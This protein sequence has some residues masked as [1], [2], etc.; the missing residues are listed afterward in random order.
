MQETG[1]YRA[2]D[3]VN[4]HARLMIS[5]VIVA[6]L[7]LGLAGSIVAN[8]D[9]P[10]F[11]PAGEIFETADRADNVLRSESSV[12]SATFLVEA[13]DGG[14]VLTAAGLREWLAASDRVRT[15]DA[16][17]HLVN[18][19]DSDLD[20][21][22]DGIVS[23]ADAVDSALPGGLA[24]AS[25]TEV[26]AALDDLLA[27][28]AHT[29]SFVFSLSEQ[30]S[31]TGGIWTSP[32]F[33]AQVVFDDATF[34]SSSA[35]EQWLRD[36]QATV[37][38]DASV[39][40]PIGVAIDGDLTFEEA[41]QDSSPFI[42]L[43]VALI[44][45]LVAIV[46][47][48]YWSSAVLAVGLGATMLAYYGFAS[49]I[50][51]KM[52]SLLLAFI[53]P[54]AMVSFGVDFYIHG[55]G[56]V[57]ES[58]LGGSSGGNSAY[59]AGMRAVF[60]AMLLAALSSIAA[61]LSNAV[62]GTEAIIQFGVGSAIAIGA[63]YLILGLMAPRALLALE[64]YIG[65]SPRLGWSRPFYWVGQFVVAV[66]GGLAVALA[67]VVPSI[68]TAAVAVLVVVVAIAPAMA[69]RR[70][71]RRAVRHGR[72]LRHGAKGVAHGIRPVGGFVTGLAARR[73]V[74]I[75]MILVV[76][77]LG[78]GAALN[79]RSG[80]EINDFLASDTDFV[81]SIERTFTHFPSSGEGSSYIFVEGDL[82]NPDALA[83]IDGAVA[84]IDAS[85]AGFGR[86]SSGELIV[87]L[88]AAEIVR[89]TA[90]DSAAAKAIAATGVIL[91][92]LD[93]DGLP[94][95]ATQVRAVYDYVGVHG[96]PSSDGGVAVAAEEVA[97]ILFDDGTADQATAIVVQVGSFT[98]GAIIVPVRAALEEAAATIEIA[99]PSVSALVSGDVI[100]QFVSLESF[101]NSTLL[102]LPLAVLLTLLIAFV[103]LR[104]LRYAVAAVLP[105]GFV[106]TGV[107]AFMSVAGYTVN[108][109][110]AT[111]AAIAVGVGIDFSTHFTAR[112]R[113]E[114]GVKGDRLEALRRAG[115]G[116]GGALVLSAATS[117]LGFLVMALAPTPIF[118]TFGALTAVMIGFALLAS[119]V[120]LPTILLLVTAP[121]A[122][123]AAVAAAVELEPAPAVA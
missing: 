107:Y 88:H 82:T 45:L 75:P 58:Q 93:R 9:E 3:W 90:S 62:S 71:N 89:M 55:T 61:F 20:V 103:M 2:F 86:R 18:T 5:G 37:R 70:R 118:A 34:Q 105:I 11:D 41:A 30:G 40:D 47:R 43:A 36:V 113:E 97:G 74:T 81:K 39:I 51:L 66:V 35:V 42:F 94:D 110:T 67:A 16:N 23:I 53:V 48:S 108:V 109:V 117:I 102:S 79:V 13:G 10:N 122:E 52:G 98:D 77:A 92:D 8:G 46:H 29:A 60:G 44:V 65:P 14:D 22:V 4:R 1:I 83:A 63:A 112:F 111:I 91:T 64:D 120:V 38:A 68:G 26:K 95:S 114:L 80:F 31:Y 57:R 6:V 27:T 12:A 123:E 54:I 50:G 28:D 115:E 87:G 69:T 19:Y 96:V 17:D 100:A 101:T 32:A 56:R 121:M 25:D 33:T 49:L 104:S 85:A 119:L 59:P 15:S 106:V 99:A 7:A 72:E 84:E 73:A 78:V 21:R 116:T 24:G 76:T